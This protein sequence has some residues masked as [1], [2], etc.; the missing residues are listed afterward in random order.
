MREPFLGFLKTLPELAGYLRDLAKSQKEL[1]DAHTSTERSIERLTLAIRDLANHEG[2][3]SNILAE[4]RSVIRS[5]RETAPPT[6]EEIAEAVVPGWLQ[7]NE[8]MR[9]EELQS[10]YFSIDGKY[11][12]E[13]KL[14][15]EGTKNGEKVTVLGEYKPRIF[16]GDVE[17]F[18]MNMKDVERQMPGR[19]CL[20][21][22]FGYVVHPTALEAAK[23]YDVR[24]IASHQR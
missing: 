6:L 17:S 1:A 22:L 15:G 2:Q 24:V 11:L 10:N 18:V 13:V 20:K 7:R 14:Y 16:G 19:R 12:I 9:I 3:T 4:V 5:L 21:F 8:G 23:K